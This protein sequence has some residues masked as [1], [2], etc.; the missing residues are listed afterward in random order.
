MGRFST[1]RL[2]FCT[3]ELSEGNRHSNDEFPVLLAGGGGGRLNT[4]LHVRRPNQNA[5]LAGITALRAAGIPVGSFGH[6]PGRV[7]DDISELLNT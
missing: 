3:T 7:E 5:S 4:G 1:I 6:G 2:F